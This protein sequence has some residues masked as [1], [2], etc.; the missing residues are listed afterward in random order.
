MNGQSSERPDPQLRLLRALIEEHATI[1]G[2]I[3]EVGIG[4][5][6]IHGSIPVDGEVLIA[7]YDSPDRARMTLDKLPRT[8]TEPPDPDTTVGDTIADR[9]R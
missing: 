8:N 6:A 3:V 4:T 9:P 1:A 5:W 7:E 2:D